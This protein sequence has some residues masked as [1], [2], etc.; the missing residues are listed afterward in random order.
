MTPQSPP[1]QPKT[2]VV[3][4]RALRDGVYDAILEKLLDGST[5]PGSSLNI[6]SLSREL[7][8]SQT[9]VREALVQME[10]TG[11]VARTA[12]KG[13]RVAPPLSADQMT[14]LMDAR[15]VVEL[16]AVERAALRA[17]DLLSELRAAH[18]R[19]VLAAHEVARLRSGEGPPTGYADL[20]ECFTADWAFHLVIIRAGGNHF[21]TQMAESLNAHAHRLRQ[22]VDHG[23]FDTDQAVTEHAAILAAFESDDPTAPVEAMRAHL[24]AIDRRSHA[25]EDGGG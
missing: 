3:P 5:P 8:V 12:L 18:A 9:P 23:T 7:G 11:L 15:A 4:R 24:T 14:E 2:S 17:A 6:D 1:T 13:Y 21:L 16:A 25:E 19:H 10:H 20:R 22:S